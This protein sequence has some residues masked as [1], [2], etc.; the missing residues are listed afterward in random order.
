MIGR[1]SSVGLELDLA[2]GSRV[3]TRRE[4]KVERGPIPG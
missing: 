4:C 3:S 1:A 2:E